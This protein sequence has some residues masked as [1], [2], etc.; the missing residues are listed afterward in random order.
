MVFPILYHSVLPVASHQWLPDYSNFKWA[1]IPS[2]SNNE[3][4]N[5]KI[6]SKFKMYK[7]L[8]N[9]FLSPWDSASV[10]F[11][12]AKPRYPIS[13]LTC[14]CR[15]RWRVG[16]LSLEK[17]CL[18]VKCMNCMCRMDPKFR[19]HSIQNKEVLHYFMHGQ[20]FQAQFCLFISV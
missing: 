10:P 12:R 13:T 3:I 1:L 4:G 7:P 19:K 15:W 18:N 11:P 9:D 16:Y 8:I 17:M 6:S 2:T 20:G 5:N 14:R